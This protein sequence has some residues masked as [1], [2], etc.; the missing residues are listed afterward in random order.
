[1]RAAKAEEVVKKYHPDVVYF[2]S[3]AF[4]INEDL[5][6]IAYNVWAVPSDLKA[7]CPSQSPPLKL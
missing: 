1:M 7:L 4:I 6:L 2:D 3:R 5:R